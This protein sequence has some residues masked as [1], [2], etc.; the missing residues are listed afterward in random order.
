VIAQLES[1]G[2]VTRSWIGVQAQPVTSSIADA[3]GLKTAEGA[4]VVEPQPGGPAAKIGIKASDV[5]TA[6]DGTAIKDSREFAQKISTLAP[7]Q[8][9][10]LTVLRDGVAKILTITPEAMPPDQQTH[11]E[12]VASKASADRGSD[13]GLTLA[14]AASVVG[15]GQEGVAV[16]AITPDGSGAQ[17]GVEV[18]D[19][20]LSVGE[21]AVS[22]PD[23]VRQQLAD[24]RKAGKHNMLMRIKSDQGTRYVALPLG[25]E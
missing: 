11:T 25:R 13:L 8:P 3:L 21:Q 7:G 12:R 9:A 6:V 17:N 15:A 10:T 24:L 1:Q 14:P 4:L 2:H 23:D 16:I 5:I 22:N 20:I 19:I 18:G